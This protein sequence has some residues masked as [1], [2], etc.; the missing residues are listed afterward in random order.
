MTVLG[1]GIFGRLLGID[2]M[3]RVGPV[4]GLVPSQEEKRYQ[5]FSLPP[6]DTERRRPSTNQKEGSHWDLNLNLGLFKLW[7][8]KKGRSEATSELAQNPQAV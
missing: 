7:K 1:S 3:V 6:E 5:S 4:M 2:E 8:H